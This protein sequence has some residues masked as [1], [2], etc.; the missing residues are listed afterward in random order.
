MNAKDFLPD[1]EVNELIRRFKSDRDSDAL[2]TLCENYD[3]FVHWCARKKLA[4]IV[5]LTPKQRMDMEP[6]LFQAGWQGFIEAVPNFDETSG[7]KFSTYVR[8]YIDGQMSKELDVLLNRAGVTDK[9]KPKVGKAKASKVASDKADD[10]VSSKRRPLQLADVLKLFSDE[11]HSITKT[12]LRDNLHKYRLIKYGEDSKLETPLTISDT[13]DAV[14]QEREIKAKVNEGKG[15]KAPEITDLQY[16]HLFSN[17]QLDELIQMICFTE[18][19]AQEEKEELIRKLLSTASLYYETPFW[20]GLKLK[21]NPSAVYGRYSGKTSSSRKDFSSNIKTIQKAI[22]SAAQ[23]SFL[24]NRYNSNHELEP[25]RNTIHKMS[26]YRIVVYHDNFYCIGL[27]EGA[28]NYSHYRIDL[29]SEVKIEYD[30]EGRTVPIRLSNFEGIPICNATWDP[31]KY[32]A[33][34]LNM[35]YETPTS[36]PRDILI[37]IKD[38]D[39]TILHDWFGNHYEKTSLSKDPGYDIVR[40]KTSPSMLV[41]WAMQYG[42]RVEILD[43]RIRESIR[44]EIEALEEMYG[45]NR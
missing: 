29:M 16:V 3:R 30:E 33:E 32:M 26:P 18:L 13:L 38:T 39:Y 10:I 11:N 6:D 34:H 8:K 24:F 12:E 4:R 31:A 27:W 9:P 22:D 44:K 21:F 41:H 5:S 14:L 36:K 43:K 20:D 17:E 15:K 40:V 35:A 37:K 45:D 19:L 28:K 25:S 1:S 7:G 2:E 42:T 23:I